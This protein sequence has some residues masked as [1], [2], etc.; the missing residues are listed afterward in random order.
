MAF[1]SIENETPAVVRDR[2]HILRAVA[3]GLL[4]TQVHLLN[5]PDSM[6]SEL[7]SRFIHALAG[8]G[9]ELKIRRGPR[10]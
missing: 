3:H 10:P 5:H 8:H 9:V 4:A 6:L 2:K 1:S 7:A